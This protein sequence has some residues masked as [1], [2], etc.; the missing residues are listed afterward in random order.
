M[1]RTGGDKSIVNNYPIRLRCVYHAQNAAPTYHTQLLV[2]D[3]TVSHSF[4]QGAII[5]PSTLQ[6]IVVSHLWFSST[7]NSV[8]II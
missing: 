4:G 5:I 8:A 2:R 3:T 6:D 1:K 7:V